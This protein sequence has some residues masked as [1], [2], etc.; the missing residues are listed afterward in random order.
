MEFLEDRRMMATISWIN[1][2]GGSWNNA[3][4]WSGGALPGPSDDVVIDVAGVNTITHSSGIDT[5]R[6][7]TSQE[8][9]TLSGG[10]LKVTGAVQGAG[11]IT[12]AGGTLADAVVQQVI[13]ATTAGGTLSGVT[14][15]G[16]P[17]QTQP[18]L[19]D[20]TAVAG[21]NVSVAGGLTLNN[22][23]VALGN[24]SGSYGILR[25]SD[26]NSV[27]DGTNGSVVFS[28]LSN[29]HANTLQQNLAGGTLTI[30]PGIT[31]HGG[32]GSIGYN[33]NI[34]GPANVVVINQGSILADSAGTLTVN[35]T[36]WSNSGA[37]QA[38]GA[39]V[40]SLAGSWSNTGLLGELNATLN[41]GG[42]F[43]TA[44]LGGFSRTGGIVNLTGALNNAGSTLA[45]NATTGSWNL[46]GGTIAGGTVTV[47]GDSRL[48]GTN[49]GGTFSGGV[50][51][52]GDPLLTQPQVL[53]L[54]AAAG[55]NVSVAGGLT[56]NNTTVSLGNSSGSYGIL[57]FSDANSVLDGTNGSVVFSNLSNSYANTL[58]ENLAGG[59]LTIG[60]GITIHGGTGSIGYNPNIGGPANVAVINQGTILADS[61]GTLSINGT[62]WSNSGALQAAG[63]GVLSLAGSWSN[64]GLLGELNAT[65]NLG[66][67]FSTAS[68]GG[69]SR[70]GGIVNLTGALNNAGST[71]A[72]NA[73]T[74]SW[75][76]AGGTI[77]GGTVTVTGD[78]RLIGTNLGGTFSGGVTL[79]GDP[80]LT[81]PQVLDL[82]AAANANVSVAGGLTLNNTTVALGNSSGSYGI[83]R[84]SDA[85]SVLDG[86]NGSVVF[87]N[88]SNSYANTLQEN[89]A[90]GTLT[91]GP[92][93]TIHGGT[94]SIGYNPNIGGPAN[95]A[96][97]NQ[98]TILADSAGTLSI[99]GT[100]WS[101]SGA[102]QAAGA[103]VLSLAGSWSNTGLLGELN[104]TL[105]LG[106]TFSTAS[107]GGFSRT[108]GIVNLTG[109]L[110]NAGSTLALN[111]TTGSWNLAGGTI[112]G[113]TVTVT[114]DSRLIGTNLGGTFSG[115]VT[116]QG[117]PLLTQPQV[118]DLTAAANANVSVAGGLTLNNTT[119][120]LGN[121]SGNYGILRFSDANSVLDGTNGSVVFSN[122][123]NSYANTLQENLAGGTLT[124][125][126]GITIHGGTG[127]IGYNPNIGGPASVAVINRGSILADSAGTLSINGTNWSNSG[128][129]QAAGAGV[130]SLAGS[131]SNT[132]LLG[133][134]NAT[135][136][137]GGTF[138]TASLGGFSR[139][140]GIV[141][142]TGA[143]NNA[144]STLALNATTGSWNL[145]GGTIAGGTVT[146]TGDSRLIGTNLG[147]TFSGGVTL[148]GDPLLTQP[149]VLDL[150]AAAN[151]NVSVAGGLTLNNTTVALGNSSG[152][153][154]ILRFSDANSVLDGTNGSVVFSNLSNSY[155]NT[156][157]ENLAGGTLTI[158]SGITIHGGT[159]SIGYNPNIGG[160]ANV[161]VIN[162]GSILADSAGTLTVGGASATNLG[163]FQ[164]AGGGTL[165]VQ[166][167]TLTNFSAGTLTGGI[168]TASAGGTLQ[169]RNADITT[170][171]ASIVFD[172][173]G[174]RLTKDIAGGSAPGELRPQ[175]GRR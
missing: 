22:T 133:E 129:L 103:G 60:P 135:L 123:S 84:F 46:A 117:D 118:L 2:I 95:V 112:A 55:A 151:A 52:Q 104:A 68:L 128:A 53:D 24:S 63:A 71:L 36:N 30:G 99:N 16:D 44:S 48:I 145:A 7:L 23:T 109:A 73:T 134:L 125:G 31:I 148:Q 155:A 170:N 14:L 146:V 38:A 62:N 75:N 136:N 26:A 35:G 105:N 149:Q 144:G 4:N 115:G 121:S 76:L 6:S 172:G 15:T 143:L 119:V 72:L 27:L 12:L 167:T 90:G 40:L 127:S 70:T 74:G 58:Q 82:T 154:G 78:S 33:P 116:L 153:Y 108:G 142:L 114:G 122:L 168:W 150:T 10:T 66:G 21:A 107:L 120:A 19:L 9:V 42:T 157:Q 160:P 54:T 34:G 8:I 98:G 124:I 164:A 28:N 113:G 83:L 161:A 45:L 50:T 89:L 140:G 29:S 173:A 67:T 18:T 81:Q 39:G 91:I 94:G 159:G 162:Q 137:L 102:L 57:R 61:A 5:I 13:M 163:T 43:S 101:N 166:P 77:A 174:G 111:A 87:S 3:A 171:A 85:N 158:G 86:T 37:L 175:L 92:G 88:L 165:I 79:Q 59:T 106:G 41:L 65:L 11:T 47:T 100:N 96:V 49:L 141:N 152:N 132:G 56:L 20:L 93:I 25:F 1:A 126:S 131:W 139:T 64:T 51:L 169:V 69:F 147:G 17:V 130:L 97:I 110:N 32:S 138:S 156:L 80:L